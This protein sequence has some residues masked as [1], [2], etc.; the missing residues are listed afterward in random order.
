VLMKQLKLALDRLPPGR[1][2]RA[3]ITVYLTTLIGWLNTDPWPRDRRFQSLPLTPAAIE[4][5]L[6]V[7]VAGQ[8]TDDIYSADELAE[9]CERL[10]ILGGPGSGKTWLA[11]RTARRCAENALELLRA[12]ATLDEV[13]LP[14]YT[15]CSRLFA[16]EG[17]IRSAAVSSAID[18][19]PDLGGSRINTAL[20]AFFTERSRRMI[21]VIDSLDEASSRDERLRQADTLPWR[22]VLTSRPSSWNDQ[23]TIRSHDES[24]QVGELQPLLYPDDVEPFIARWFVREPNQGKTLAGQIAKRV[25]LQQAATVPL[26]L[27][28]YCIIGG[29]AALPQFRHELYAKVLNRM[30]T[31]RWRGAEE[32]EPDVSGC[33]RTLRS[34]AWSAASSHPTSGVGTWVDDFPTERETLRAVDE[35]ALDHVATPLGPADVDSGQTLRRFIHRSI[36]EHLVAEHLST[37]SVDRAA[38]ALLPHLWYDPDWEYSAPAALAMHPQRNRLL[39]ELIYRT[40]RLDYLSAKIPFV[41]TAWEIRRLLA[42]VATQSIE[43]DWSFE[44]VT[45][46]GRARVNLAESGDFDD[47]GRPA[48][49]ES[50]NRDIRQILISW[51]GDEQINV[52]EAEELA[53]LLAQLNP[54]AEEMGKARDLLLDLLASERE[55]ELIEWWIDFLMPFILTAEDKRQVC[56]ALVRM[57]SDEADGS[58]AGVLAVT[59][60]RF[61][62]TPEEQRQVRERLLQ[63]LAED[64]GN[65]AMD[66]VVGLVSTTPTVEDQ[67]QIRQHLLET[68]AE[69]NNSRVAEALVNGIVSF[70]KTIGDGRATNRVLLKMLTSEI[71]GWIAEALLSGIVELAQED[72]EKVEAREFILRLLAGRAEEYLIN[73][74]AAALVILDPTA[75]EKRRA[76]LMV[77]EL[78]ARQMRGWA[79][80]G[81]AANL[82]Q[83]DPTLDD[84]RRV[85]AILFRLLSKEKNSW[86]AV[87]VARELSRYGP[88][89][90]YQRYV[91]GQLLLLLVGES[92]PKLISEIV[93]VFIEF[94]PTPE[95]RR[96][97]CRTLIALVALQ[98]S[99]S[100]TGKLSFSLSQL[101]RTT[102]DRSWVRQELLRLL[103]SRN[104][105]RAA[106]R[107]VETLD[108]LD[109]TPDE[110][111]RARAVLVRFLNVKP[112]DTVTE[113]LVNGLVQMS[114]A[115]ETRPA[116]DVLLGFLTDRIEPRAAEVLLRNIAKLTQSVDDKRHVREVLLGLLCTS[117]DGSLASKFADRL[118]QFDPTI[119][120]MIQARQAL[121][122]LLTKE[123]HPQAAESLT[124]S[125]GQFNPTIRDVS[126]WRGWTIEPSAEL[127]AAV[128]RNSSLAEWL[129]AVPSMTS[130]FE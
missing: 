39:Q 74:L 12:G 51:L 86:V 21:F 23:L 128:R 19:L 44:L 94:V 75:D 43:A 45:M 61:A 91:C 123:V 49:W 63:L 104:N 62:P 6:L 25:D 24:H 67:R 80:W 95:E 106:T 1:A 85:R 107:L 35:R 108:M 9:Q 27:A 46:I 42:R 96:Q 122:R 93:S 58:I 2:D 117:V 130:V 115:K 16:A 4:R 56:T 10:V 114:P 89:V 66:V 59:L 53:G 83:L 76:R 110:R 52:A 103:C 73:R 88:T 48:N 77:I 5:K 40:T 126:S 30:L 79:A 72:I 15:T 113:R 99:I 105:G 38:E 20:S 41:D 18:Q 124:R 112:N 68:L 64:D 120:D 100:E 92:E 36:R 55:T 22:I 129:T 78:L 26:I 14:L 81:I 32:G 109:P 54:T 7:N 69:E 116:L 71:E 34:W 119:E 97:A 17:D 111:R 65:S 3:E 118:A 102:E 121:L 31:G 11:K 8:T 82:A 70:A 28:F 47:L 33:L 29:D 127:L 101:A 87:R 90:E 60:T 98:I 50:S 125:L 84:Q 13:E 37:L 57:F